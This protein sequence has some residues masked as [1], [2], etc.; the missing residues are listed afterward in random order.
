MDV[1]QSKIT[2]CQN[3]KKLRKENNI[4]QKALA[5]KLKTSVK[6]V[7]HWETG[8]SEPS[9]LQLRVLADLFNITADELLGKE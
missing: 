3:L 5:E 2:F 9:L 8:Y 1:L 4:S 6:T 7:S